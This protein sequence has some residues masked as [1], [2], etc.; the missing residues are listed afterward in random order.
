MIT[1]D[2][3]TDMSHTQLWCAVTED[4]DTGEICVYADWQPALKEEVEARGWLALPWTA[5]KPQP[6]TGHNAIKFDFPKLGE[7]AGVEWPMTDMMDT[8]IMAKM[9]NRNMDGGHSLK[10]WGE[11]LRQ[12]GALRAGSTGKL[13]Y[14]D[15]DAPLDLDKIVYCVE[16]VRTTTDLHRYLEQQMEAIGFNLDCIPAEMMVA[17]YTVQQTRNGFAFDIQACQKLYAQ[18][19]IRQQEIEDQLQEVFPPIVE[20]RY[21]EKTGKR[22]MDKVEVFNP[23]SQ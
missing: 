23:G 5:L 11:R 9:Y 2:I 22:L 8:L 7:L 20:E 4:H 18:L 16:D 14:E 13:E 19:T 10:V 3:E 1:I 6:A 12:A 21:S 17:Y 15:H